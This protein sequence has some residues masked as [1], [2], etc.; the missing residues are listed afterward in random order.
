MA[1]P[2]CLVMVQRVQEEAGDIPVTSLNPGTRRS[3]IALEALNDACSDIW[4]RERWPWRRYDYNLVLT[5]GVSEYTL[6]STFGS[7]A[8]PP[9]LPA[10]GNYLY[11]IEMTPE[12]WAVWMAAPPATAGSPNKFKI[13]NTKIVFSPTPNSDYVTSYPSILMSY[14]KKIPDRRAITDGASSWDVPDDF[15]DA[16]I[17]RGKARLKQYLEFPDWQ[18]DMQAYEQ[19][20]R[21]QQNRVRQGRSPATVRPLYPSIS[22]W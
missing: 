11:M 15:Y 5:D 4:Q 22:E 1:L 2:S 19:S 10:A 7:L 13:E 8:E 6:P 16:M 21:I 20:I 12:E 3:K 14:F 9:R 18:A 17:L